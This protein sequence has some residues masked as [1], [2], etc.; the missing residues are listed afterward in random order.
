MSLGDIIKAVF[1]LRSDMRSAGADESE[2]EKATE[3][4]VRSAWP[5]GR[6]WKYLC[7]NCRDY[8]LEMLECPGDA[9]CGRDK[10]HRPH[11][12]GRPCWC[13]A[14]AKFRARLKSEEDFQQA[15]KTPKRSGFSRVGR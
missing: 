12:F 14:G 3:R 1:D 5:P 8:G 10:Q 6:E 9:T 11:D 7:Q 2:I 15:G 4:S 13:D